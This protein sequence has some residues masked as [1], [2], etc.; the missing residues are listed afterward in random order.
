MNSKPNGL[1]VCK[2]HFPVFCKFLVKKLKHFDEK[3]RQ[4]DQNY[5]TQ[6]LGIRAFLENGSGA[7]L[8]SKTNVVSV[9]KEHFSVFCRFLSDEV[10]IIFWE[11]ETKHLGL[12]KSK[13][14]R[15]KLMRNLLLA[16]WGPKTNVMSV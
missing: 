9:L 8:S 11:S 10:Q 4:S 5:L 3:V 2:E 12:F 16:T 6:N 14:G 1:S 13:F 7:T 15:S